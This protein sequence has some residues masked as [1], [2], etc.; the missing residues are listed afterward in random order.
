MFIFLNMNYSS[1]FPVLNIVMIT[2]LA[3]IEVAP[4]RIGFR[5]WKER[6]IALM[7]LPQKKKVTEVRSERLADVVLVEVSQNY[8]A[9]GYSST[10]HLNSE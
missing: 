6:A 2:V 1:L 9:H 8:G 10:L 3:L 7:E 5:Q 4:A